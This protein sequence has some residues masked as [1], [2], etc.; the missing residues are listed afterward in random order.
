MNSTDLKIFFRDLAL[1]FII[2]VSILFVINVSGI[3]DYHEKS[4]KPEQMWRNLTKKN[5]INTNE[6]I[7]SGNSQ[8]YFLNPKII[9][10]ITQKTSHCYAYPGANI[11]PISWFFFNSF[12]YLNPELLVLETH[13]FSKL[14][15]S[16]SIDSI[17]YKRWEDDYPQFTEY[18]LSLNYINWSEFT[19][20]ETN[21][22][23]IPYLIKGSAVKNHH[24]LETNIDNFYKYFFRP[25]RNS[26][27]GFRKSPYS[28]ISDSLLNIY[29]TERIPSSLP[30]IA[31]KEFQIVESIIKRFKNKG[32]KVMICES[33]MYYQHFETNTLR[34][35]ALDSFCLHLNVP[36]LN[37]NLDTSLTRLP[38]YFQNT[39]N[40]NQHLTIEG[41]NAVS[42]TIANYILEQNLLDKI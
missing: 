27:Q 25:K 38:Q 16:S 12:D 42:K 29:N 6:I 11:K 34:R 26:L 39:T 35:E 15:G 28:P 13:S 1:G 32:I 24:L 3:F 17:R 19:F 7:F 2:L 21:K 22:P 18:S 5:K 30:I 4:S 10:S 37:L 9:D 31:E 36:F 23:E 40:I 33:P 41:S 14:V 8:I 20:L